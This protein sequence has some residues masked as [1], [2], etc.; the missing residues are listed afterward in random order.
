VKAGDED[1]LLVVGDAVEDRHPREVAVGERVTDR[2]G[3][4]FS[5]HDAW[6]RCAG[7]VV[8]ERLYRHV[9]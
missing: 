2:L 4:D 5:I 7:E 9:A 3:Q 1:Q 8:D 6:D